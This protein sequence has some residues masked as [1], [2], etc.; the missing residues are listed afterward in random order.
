MKRMLGVLSVGAMLLMGGQAYALNF[1]P[2]GPY[3]L[4]T[5]IGTGPT[6]ETMLDQAWGS[7]QNWTLQYKSDVCD[8]A[9]PN[10]NG[11]DSGPQ[12]GNYNTLFSNSATDPSNATIS[13]VAQANSI[14][15]LT[16]NCMLEVKDGSQT[17]G[18]YFFNLTQAVW[19][20]TDAIN[21]TN[22]WTG[23]GA[24]SHVTIWS[25]GPVGVPEPASLLLLGAGL[26]GLG[27]WR[28]KQA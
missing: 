12:A 6:T 16:I 4:G 18:R 27:I 3:L 24:I 19:N 25:D 1:G 7:D 15:C 8:P 10:G 23:N 28:R 21:L 13:H 5:N 22:F 9:D 26:A 17:P 2:S 11:C 14:N 20:G